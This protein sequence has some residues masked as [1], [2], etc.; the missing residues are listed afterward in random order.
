MKTAKQN[1]SFTEKGKSYSKSALIVDQTKESLN[2]PISSLRRALPSACLFY[3]AFSM[4]LTSSI[5]SIDL[6]HL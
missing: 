6:K 3:I 5:N 2:N 4:L 1:V